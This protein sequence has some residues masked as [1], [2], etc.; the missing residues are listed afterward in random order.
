[1]A[2]HG[3]HA[4]SKGLLFDIGSPDLDIPGYKR[5][6]LG[7]ASN[8][9][10]ADPGPLA[11]IS[12]NQCTATF[13]TLKSDLETVMQLQMLKSFADEACDAFIAIQQDI[14]R[15]EKE[16]IK[17]IHAQD[18]HFIAAALVLPQK[19]RLRSMTKRKITDPETTVG[20]LMDYALQALALLGGSGR[21]HQIIEQ[22]EPLVKD[23]LLPA[24]YV[25]LH[26]G[27]SGQEYAPIG[28]TDRT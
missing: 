14:E 11:L 2:S 7:G 18:R 5:T 9:G 6:S 13:L 10:F 15:A 26:N 21:R 28:C 1:M 19:E 4:N 27:E 20:T 17:A 22:V 3:V 16:C 25:L 24:D 8:T 12:L 23:I